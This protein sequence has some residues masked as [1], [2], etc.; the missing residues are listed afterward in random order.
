MKAAIEFKAEARP[1]AGKGAARQARRDGKVP[2]NVYG[3]GKGNISMN[4]EARLLS[5]EY[6]RGGFMNK[7]ISLNL[8]GKNIF[9]IP[10]DIQLNPVTDKIEHADFLAV[11]DKSVVKVRIPVH[12]LNADKSIGLKR[13]GVLN[14]VARNV[15]LLCPVANIPTSLDI[16]LAALEIGSTV[17]INNVELPKGVTA[18]AKGRDFTIASIAGR[19]KEE[20]ADVTAAPVAGAVPA[21]KA[22]AATAAAAAAPAAAAGKAAAK[23][24]AKK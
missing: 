20:E 3:K 17:H 8:D 15:E 12:F 2:V 18:A 10:R 22:T 13:G 4:V 24:A 16:D 1:V 21:T 6:F 19:Q 5:N 14:I 23:P 9:A 11:D 7:V